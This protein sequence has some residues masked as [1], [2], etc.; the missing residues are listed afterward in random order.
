MPLSSVGRGV[1]E[2]AARRVERAFAWVRICFCCVILLRFFWVTEPI[3]PLRLTCTVVPIALAC[4]SSIWLL[5]RRE[6]VGLAVRAGSA[7]LDV[8][9][10]VLVLVPMAVLPAEGSASLLRKPDLAVLMLVVMARDSDSPHPSA[11]SQGSS[12]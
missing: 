10:A 12:P 7:G 5:R 8:W 3:D 4:G 9:V 1:V 6:P 11:S 2:A